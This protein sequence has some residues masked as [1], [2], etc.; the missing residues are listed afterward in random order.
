[1]AK[2]TG[3]TPSVSFP[4]GGSGKMF[5]RQYA[6]GQKSGTTAHDVPDGE[7][8]FATGGSGHMFG[9]GSASAMPSGVTARK[10]Q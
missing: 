8:K 1:M 7:K 9:K 4:K 5:G 3:G 2:T 6:N 10:G